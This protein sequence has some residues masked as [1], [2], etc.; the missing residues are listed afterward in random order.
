M[1]NLCMRILDVANYEG[2]V[3]EANL[4]KGGKYATVKFETQNGETV[5]LSIS[6]EE[7]EVKADE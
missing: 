5:T 1:R 3:T 7:K 6:K 2:D 4:Y